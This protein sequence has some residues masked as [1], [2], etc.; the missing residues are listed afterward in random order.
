[1]QKINYC[2]TVYSYRPVIRS[3]T[4]KLTD[5][6]NFF[7]YTHIYIR[8]P[9][10]NMFNYVKRDR[11]SKEREKQILIFLNRLNNNIYFLLLV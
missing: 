7:V 3:S 9:I 2:C 5:L 1:M 8:S 6:F 4:N 10:Q 11:I